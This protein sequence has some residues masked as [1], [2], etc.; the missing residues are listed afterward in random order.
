MLREERWVPSFET[1]GGMGKTLVAL[2]WVGPQDVVLLAILGAFLQSV[3][4]TESKKEMTSLPVPV[5]S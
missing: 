5:T 2:K 4:G 1:A 3:A